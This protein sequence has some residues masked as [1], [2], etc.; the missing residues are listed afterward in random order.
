[1]VNIAR[2]PCPGPG[3]GPRPHRHRRPLRHQA[4]ARLPLRRRQ[5]RRV[6]RR[7]PA[8]ARP[9][10]QGARQSAADRAPVPRRRGSRQ[11][12]LGQPE[13]RPHLR[14][15]LLRRAGEEGGDDGRTSSAFILVDMIGDRDLGIQRE[16]NST[17]WLT[18]A[19]WSAAQAPEAARVPRQRHA[20]RGRPPRVPRRRH[21]LGRHHRPQLP[22]LAHGA[23]RSSTTCPPAASRSSATSCSPRCP[24]SKPA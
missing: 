19:V 13:H 22:R 15:P 6:E 2:R 16:S 10:A 18:D 1:M 7:L 8:G 21:P 5:R 4:V 23:G 14:Q 20:D 9:R 3:A 12:G 17:A 24:R 11:L